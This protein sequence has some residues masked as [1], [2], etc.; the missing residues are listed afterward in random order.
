MEAGRGGT[1]A[2]GRAPWPTW[3]G[4]RGRRSLWIVG[5]LAAVAGVVGGIYTE[6]Y[7]RERYVDPHTSCLSNLRQISAGLRAYADD[8]DGV[9]PG[10]RT[11]RLDLDRYMLNLL[12]FQCPLTGRT[13]MSYAHAAPSYAYAEY[14]SGRSPAAI[15]SPRETPAIWDMDVDTGEPAFRHKRGINV[16]YVDGHAGW[17]RPAAFRARLDD[18][19]V[20]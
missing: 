13:D 20:R 6:W 4:R 17:L 16:A 1:Q 8:H 18:V 15:P 7:L 19:A 5:I 12:V 11:W 14:L 9:Y 2:N 3:R 10:S